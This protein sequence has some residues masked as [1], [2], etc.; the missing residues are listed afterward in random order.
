MKRGQRHW[1]AG[2]GAAKY[3][4]SG[5]DLVDRRGRQYRTSRYRKRRANPARS[6]EPVH[7]RKLP[8]R[9]PG[10]LG[11]ARREEQAGGERLRPH[12][13]RVRRRG[14]G[15]G[16]ST[17]ERFEQGRVRAG[18]ESGG[19]RPRHRERPT[20]THGPRA[21]AGSRVPGAGGRAASSTEEGDGEVYFAVASSHAGTSAQQ[22]LRLKEASGGGSRWGE[23]T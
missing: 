18:G 20:A 2:Y 6:R 9:E 16:G 7:V 22:L 19:K 10:D 17:E 12:A 23:L 4:V 3:L 13:P 8:A 14:V 5:A 1:R 11:D 15:A 21:A